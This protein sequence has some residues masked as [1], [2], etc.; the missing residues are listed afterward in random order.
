MGELGSDAPRLHTEIGE[1]AKAAGIE[2]IY[3]LGELT[4]NAVEAFGPNAIRFDSVESLWERLK[5]E[6]DAD[7]TVLVKGS[8]FMRME[9]VVEKLLE[10]E[11]SCY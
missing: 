8:R 7:T 1:A 4:R 5:G 6:L 3:A 2:R 9:R 11:A 10:Q